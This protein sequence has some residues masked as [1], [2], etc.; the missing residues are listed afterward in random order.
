MKNSIITLLFL[1]L[2]VAGLAQG[3]KAP[4][5]REE[6]LNAE[7]CT[8]L[9]STVDGTYF[10]LENDDNALGASSYL[11]VLNWLQGRVAG[12]QVYNFRGTP[13]PF[14]R[15]NL[16]AIYLD[17][18]RVDASFLNALPI[19]DIAMIKVIKTP[20]LGLW[21]ATGGAIAIYTKGGEEA[22]EEI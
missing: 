4:L 1:I 13:I 19:S 9:F 15:N 5:T 16:A 7:Y 10:D 14:I 22:E 12:L 17:E 18:M 6:Q 3:R 21:G 11:N 8:G 2:S 20:F